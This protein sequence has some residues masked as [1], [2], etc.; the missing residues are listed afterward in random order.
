MVDDVEAFDRLCPSLRA[1]S[2][3]ASSNAH[4]RISEP[5]YERVKLF[6]QAKSPSMTWFGTLT[7]FRR[8]SEVCFTVREHE[9]YT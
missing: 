3:K 6:Y 8:D 7:V 1:E 9:N 4:N 5:R 2:M